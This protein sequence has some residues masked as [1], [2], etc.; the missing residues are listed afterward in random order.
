[1]STVQSRKKGHKKDKAR[2]QGTLSSGKERG[3]SNTVKKTLPKVLQIGYE[4][5]RNRLTWDGWD[6]HCG[7]SMDVLL[8]DQLGS[9]TWR[10]VS[11]E[12]NDEGWYIPTYPDI[13]P[14]GLWSKEIDC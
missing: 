11:F 6:I 8:P 2:L 5:E 10:A 4:P 12:C 9:G 14:V 13:S 3:V 1:M 7:Q